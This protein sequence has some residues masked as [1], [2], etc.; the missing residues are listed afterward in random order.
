MMSFI[1]VRRT[2]GSS[3]SSAVANE[4]STSRCCFSRSFVAPSLGSSCGTSARTAFAAPA[5]ILPA[6]SARPDD[7]DARGFV[8]R[9]RMERLAVVVLL[10]ARPFDFDFAL[11]AMPV[12][13]QKAHQRGASLR[14][15]PER[16]CYTRAPISGAGFSKSAR[17]CVGVYKSV[18]ASARETREGLRDAER[19]VRPG[20]HPIEIRAQLRTC[21]EEL[22]L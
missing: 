18:R 2:F 12:V 1:A 20:V 21:A 6:V 10:R 5:S 16:R 3:L 14:A 17:A 13:E 9:R 22:R 4:R 7:T 19:R 15:L 8:T 11:V